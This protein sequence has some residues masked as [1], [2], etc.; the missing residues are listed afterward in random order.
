MRSKTLLIGMVVIAINVL[1]VGSVIT[2]SSGDLFGK[3][4]VSDGQFKIID[5]GTGIVKVTI[6][7]PS[8]D[9][10]LGKY[11]KIVRQ[12]E[13]Q[14]TD[15][16]IVY[17]HQRRVDGAIVE[18]DRIVYQFDKDTKEPIKKI[19][20]WRD[21]LPE[22]LP[23]V[24]SKE[25]AESIAKSVAKG[26]IMNTSLAHTKL[27]YISPNSCWYP[28]K[29]LP[30]NPCWI[31]YFADDR[32][33]NIDVIII[34]A[35]DGKILGYGVPFPS[36]GFSFSGPQ[37]PT[38]CTGAWEEWH[39]NAESW[40]NTMGYPTEAMLYPNEAKVKS[41]IQ[42]YETA[43]FYE[44]AHGSYDYFTN[45]C[46]GDPDGITDDEIHNWI[47]DYP[48]MPFTFIHSCGG[49]CENG[50]GTLSYEF[51]KEG[52][53]EDT[54]TVGTCLD[55]NCIEWKLEWQD[56]F[57]N[58][59]SQGWTVKNAFDQ[60]CDD[61]PEC[62]ACVRF[63]GDENLKVVPVVGRGKP[64]DVI[65]VTDLS[66]S[67]S[68]ALSD[69]KTAA[70][71]FVDQ[72]KGQDKVGL[73]S[74]TSTA[75]LDRHLTS[76]F[77]DVKNVIDGYSAGGGTNMGDG[78]TEAI[79]ELEANGRAEALHTIIVLSDG[80]TSGEDDILNTIVPQAVSAGITI[81]TFGYDGANEDFLTQV[82][83][84][85]SGEYHFEPD[86]AALTAIYTQ[87][88]QSMQ[89]EE[90]YEG[91]VGQDETA[92]ET[93]WLDK[94]IDFF[95]IILHW[96]GSDL[97]LTII[98]P[99]GT[100]I[101]PGMPGVF[102]SGN[103]TYPEYYEVHN[104]MKGNWTIQIYGKNV[105][106]E[107]ENYTVT[108]FHPG[109]LMYV[110]PTNWDIVN[111]PYD[112]STVF[113]VSEIGGMNNL[114]NVVFTASDLAEVDAAAAAARKAEMEARAEAEREIEFEKQVEGQEEGKGTNST[115]VMS[116]LHLPQEWIHLLIERLSYFSP[117]T[118][119]SKSFISQSQTMSTIPASSFSFSPNNFNVPA[120]GSQDVT[121]TLTI[122]PGTPPGDYSGTIDVTSDNGN[123][124]AISVSVH[125]SAPEPTPTPTPPPPPPPGDGGCP[126][127]TKFCDTIHGGIYFEQRGWSQFPPMTRTFDDVPDGI[128]FARVYTGIWGGR[129]GNGGE[130][131]ITVNGH[132]TDTY[133][134][135]DPC[136][137]EPCAG[138]QSDRCD[139]LNWSANSPPFVPTG[140]MHD[141]ITGCNV[142][143]ISYNAT[144]YIHPGSNT[145]TVE[146]GCSDNCTCWDGMIYLIALLV[147]YENSSMPEMTYWI[148]EGAPYMEEGSFCDG[149][150][151]N[152]EI[153]FYFNGTHIPSPAKVKYWTL[154]WPHVINAIEGPAYT[155][156][157]GYYIGYP[158]H[159]ESYIGSYNEVLLRWDNIPPS[160][161]YPDSNFIAYYDYAPYYERVNVAVLIAQG[162]VN[163]PNLKVEDIEIPRTGMR[164]GSV[165]TVK[166]TVKNDGAVAA[167][168]FNVSLSA[169]SYSGKQTNVG[170]LAPDASVTVSFTDVQ[171]S[172][173]CYDFT[174]VADCDNDVDEVAF[175]NNNEKTKKYQVGYVIVVESNSDFEEL[176]EWRLAP[177][178]P[179][180]FE[181][182]SGTYYIQNL[183][184]ENCA[185][186]GDHGWGI[187][188]ENTN[189]PFVIRNCTVHNCGYSGIFL[190]NVTNGKIADN[191]V[192]DN[193]LKGIKLR[194]CSHMDIDNNLVYDNYRYGIEVYPARMPK[195]DCKYIN[196]ANSTLT[197]NLY[198][199]ELIGCNCTVRDNIIRNNTAA[200]YSNWE[201]SGGY[202]IYCFGN[203]SKIYNNTIAYNDNYVIYMDYNT[204][205]HPC[206]CN[207]IYGNSFIRNQNYWWSTSQAYDSGDNH[208][209]S[210]V[211]LGYYNDTGVPVM[212]YIGN[213]WVD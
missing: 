212:N 28:I 150:G 11:E 71:T 19:V 74:F 61:Y 173:G 93:N 4:E 39:Q 49:M 147:V 30:K 160:Y 127:E 213:Y 79:D 97:D 177:L 20:N 174:A 192:K 105:T 6:V 184:I 73:V 196:I 50:S 47:A 137:S 62:R 168:S 132:T 165:H 3:H 96:E 84:A 77:D 12:F 60:A 143:F 208:W 58:Y 151:D 86:S 27:R 29:P 10:L 117:E 25:K 191:V 210:T 54:V 44:V 126:S 211:M 119:S 56:A 112:K 153:S 167:G 82:A 201:V 94:I 181:N 55:A 133:Q 38:N 163:N 41:H 183:N 69:A 103:D 106:G 176:N 18:G 109:A 161:L 194:S 111:Y 198:G 42:S 114:T 186:R 209:N 35:V 48:K 141:Y 78:L 17:W 63:A 149:P 36:S 13:R 169:G 203:Y 121:A 171:L 8:T 202:G 190:Y 23:P 145:I 75:T 166:V 175:E 66:G 88:S 120:G 162:P 52:S 53:T 34:D 178:P 124:A 156:L 64:L 80:W 108:V 9:E 92:E 22:H 91:P 83:T 43:M 33:Y 32:G 144:P 99:N 67:M 100:V 146:T 135:C 24:I 46:S 136:T 139:A 182:K 170:P 157:T 81:Y 89:P 138:S 59:L 115:Q 118:V 204:P 95:K 179:G 134:A 148:N 197:G 51:R 189:V 14:E 102:Y 187:R 40:F 98:D 85:A 101:E 87:L 45:D 107:Y 180:C 31:V 104:P 7:T 195:P 68:G 140:D 158:D 142:H 206:L 185:Q 207:C 199:I 2:A 122:P 128:K 130:F 72:L 16:K 37:D 113:T 26:K 164:P 154:G 131:N 172:Y 125:V 188:I 90:E 70:K 155:S 15:N 129:P 200:M 123:S 159:T 205:S 193:S 110:K 21:D 1:I 57:F 152:H 76:D 65:L 116:L 5:T